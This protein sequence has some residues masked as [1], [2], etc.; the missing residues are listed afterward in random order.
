MTSRATSRHEEYHSSSSNVV[1]TLHP[2]RPISPPQKYVE[3]N[4]N[5]LDNLLDDLKTTVNRT[6]EHLNSANTL[7]SR[8]V[9]FLS[10]S[11]TTTI[12]EE[13]SSSPAGE[14]RK[15]YK[16]SR[17]E[18]S[19]SSSNTRDGRKI[20]QPKSYESVE[21]TTITTSTSTNINQ[22]DNLLDDLK[23]ER[24]YSYDKD[25]GIDSGLLEPNTHVTKTIRTVTTN[26]SGSKN[27]NREL[28]FDSPASYDTQQR[29]R[30]RS[31]SPNY[32]EH[33]ESQILRDIKYDTEPVLDTTPNST[34]SRTYNAYSKTGNSSRNVVPYNTEIVEMDTTDLPADLKDVPISNDLLPGPGTK[35]TT[36]IKTFTYEIPNDTKMPTNKNFSYK[37]EFYNSMNSSNTYYPERDIP[38]PIKTT[39]TAVYSNET[40]NNTTLNRTDNVYPPSPQQQQQQPHP[41]TLGPNQTYYYK[42]E[43]NET[44]NNVYGRPRSPAPAPAPVNTTTSLYERNVSNTQN[45][46]H[47]PGGI[48]VYPNNA[49][50]PP[51]QPGSKQT[52]LYKKETTN[53]TNT[54]YEPPTGREYLPHD[55]YVTDPRN[56]P[57]NQPSSSPPPHH[58]PTTN[59]YYKYSSTSTTTNTNDRRHGGPGPDREPLLAPFPIDGIPQQPSSQVDGPP[60][61]LGQLLASF[62]EN[63]GRSDE[64]PYMPRKE[65]NTAL[66]TNKS[67][68]VVEPKAPTKNI[69]GP[70]VYYPPGQELFAKSE[71]QAAWRAQGGYA[72]GSGKYEYEAESKS[73]STSKSGAAV[74]PVCLP[75]CCAMPCTIM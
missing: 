22:L 10:P 5:N 75:L 62:D 41:D 32:Q 33:I 15:I 72:K 24:D 38:P 26:K 56:V 31:R 70:P 63:T 50:L 21:P 37:N 67:I 28:K 35:V 39:S 14:N 61:H 65:V 74:V 51:N 40:N 17:Y 46:Y 69:A 45:V 59:K 71:A 60:K 66:A 58:E 8:D 19:S 1:R 23:Q 36:T 11:N 49:N 25:A 52:Y 42:K 53:T 18:Y 9:Q 48:P 13:R 27:V 64:E 54:M 30:Q 29:I 12:V 6:T 2:S 55:R 4:N 16:S 20:A 7:K 47:P 57:I 34:M 68:P 43:V 3:Y 44:K 73:K